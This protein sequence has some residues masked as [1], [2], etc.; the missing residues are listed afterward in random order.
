MIGKGYHYVIKLGIANTFY[1]IIEPV[2]PGSCAR[3]YIIVRQLRG[4]WVLLSPSSLLS[5]MSF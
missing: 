2:Y 4:T 1:I 5:T 3:G